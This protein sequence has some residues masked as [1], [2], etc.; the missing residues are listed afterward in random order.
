MYT[1]KVKAKD[2]WGAESDWSTLEVIMSRSYLYTN[3]PVLNW[4]LER[5]PWVI[6]I[7]TY[8]IP[9]FLMTSS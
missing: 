4:P 5:F 8:I 3:H 1:V 7:F 9:N 6:K 2:I